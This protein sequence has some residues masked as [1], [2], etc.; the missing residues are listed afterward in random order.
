MIKPWQS[1]EMGSTSKNAPVRTNNNVH[2]CSTLV[3]TPFTT[4]QISTKF[5]LQAIITVTLFTFSA[6]FCFLKSFEVWN[7][8]CDETLWMSTTEDSCCLLRCGAVSLGVGFPL[9]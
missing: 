3:S 8:N 5:A 2:E 9:L 7:M 6:S 1:S 4:P